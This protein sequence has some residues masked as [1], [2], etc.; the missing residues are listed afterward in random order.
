M[1]EKKIDILIKKVNKALN[2]VQ[3]ETKQPIN[4]VLKEVETLLKENGYGRLAS[5]SFELDLCSHN[6]I[7]YTNEDL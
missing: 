3:E 1:T 2:E 6:L 7:H 4:K 5:I